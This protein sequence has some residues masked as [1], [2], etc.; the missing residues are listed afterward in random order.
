MGS[1]A[2]L[3]SDTSDKSNACTGEVKAVKRFVDALGEVY[4]PKRGE[5]DVGD[6]RAGGFN[7]DRF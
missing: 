1:S 7:D 3:A 6:R 2:N 5:F 4:T